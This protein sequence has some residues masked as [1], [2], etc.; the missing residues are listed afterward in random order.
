M[1][2][3]HGGVTLK[4]MN[5]PEQQSEVVK[6]QVHHSAACYAQQ[7]EALVFSL[8]HPINRM[9]EVNEKKALNQVD[10]FNY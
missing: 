6:V 1:R 10:N 9:I 8:N 2:S 5:R 3:I 4:L 7:R